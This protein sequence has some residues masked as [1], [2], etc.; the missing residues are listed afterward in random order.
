MMQV[1]VKL[2]FVCLF[3]APCCGSVLFISD[4]GSLIKKKKE[5]GKLKPALRLAASSVSGADHACI[6]HFHTYRIPVRI[7]ETNLLVPSLP[8]QSLFLFIL[9]NFIQAR[10]FTI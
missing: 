1:S 7:K 10:E 6:G 9:G 4:P 8:D 5:R 2:F 3:F